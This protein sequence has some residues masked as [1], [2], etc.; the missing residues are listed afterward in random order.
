MK[1]SIILFFIIS[2][3]IFL[4]YQSHVKLYQ[5]QSGSMLP[6]LQVG[7]III[8]VKQKKYETEDII[9]YQTENSYFITHRIVQ[10]LD[11]G[12]ITKGDSNNTE[13]ETVV[14]QEQIQGKVIFHSELL[15]KIYYYR[16]Y[17]LAICIFFIMIQTIYHKLSN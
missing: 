13:D 1:K 7:E 15:G 4:G 11:E 14:K 17:L 8:L 3:V 12:Y 9:T 6:E 16:Y 2:I 5:I 10:I